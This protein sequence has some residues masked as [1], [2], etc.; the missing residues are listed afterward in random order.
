[1][2]EGKASVT[3]IVFFLINLL[4]ISLDHFDSLL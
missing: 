3:I 1:M 4:F 2:L